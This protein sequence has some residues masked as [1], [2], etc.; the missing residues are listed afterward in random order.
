MERDQGYRGPHD[1][2]DRNTTSVLGLAI[3]RARQK[4]GMTQQQLADAAGVQRVRLAQWE[5]DIGLSTWM[6]SRR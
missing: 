1:A 6:R 2:R 4:A 5:G 3:K